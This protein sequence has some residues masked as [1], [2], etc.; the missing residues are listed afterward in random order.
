MKALKNDNVK[1]LDENRT[2]EDEILAKN[3][4][5]SKILET[6]SMY[7]ADAQSSQ[8]KANDYLEKLEKA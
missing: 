6:I 4:E 8:N 7:Q 5:I 1:L 2:L 3:S